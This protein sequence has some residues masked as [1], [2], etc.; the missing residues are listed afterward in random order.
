MAMEKIAWSIKNCRMAKTKVKTPRRNLQAARKAAGL[1]QEA[2]AAEV[3]VSPS[4]ISR[5][6]AGERDP[7]DT[8]L[9]LI[10]H[11]LGVSISELIDS[12]RT[13][14]IVRPTQKG[15]L[16]SIDRSVTQAAIGEMIVRLCGHP[17][18]LAD[19][20]ASLILSTVTIS[21][22]GTV[23]RHTPDTVRSEIAVIARTLLLLTQRP[24]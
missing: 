21:P 5:F 18:E 4:Q 14:Q 13:K 7:K 3:G 1:S 23:E 11:R 17:P 16:I 12:E 22:V 2:L 8:E 15:S 10:A 6:E 20:A 9:A 19:R 24:N